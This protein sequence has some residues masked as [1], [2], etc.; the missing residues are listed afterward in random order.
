[1]VDILIAFEM[2]HWTNDNVNLRLLASIPVQFHR[3]MH[4]HAGKK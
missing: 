3:R 4:K 2:S 1:M